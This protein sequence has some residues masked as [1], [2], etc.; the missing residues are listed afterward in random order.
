MTEYCSNVNFVGLAS[1]YPLFGSKI[2]I[3]IEFGSQSLSFLC[4]VRPLSEF[5]IVGFFEVCK[6]IKFEG[7]F[8]MD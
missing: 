7:L 3:R 4:V 5:T 1:V 2:G 6:P 8:S